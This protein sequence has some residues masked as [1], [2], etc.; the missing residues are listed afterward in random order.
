MTI[1]EIL[2]TEGIGTYELHHYTSLPNLIK[3]L[4]SKKL[5]GGSYEGSD[6]KSVATVR[7]SLG[8]SVKSFLSDDSSGGVKI[9]ID[10]RKMRDKTRGTK[11]KPIAE[12]PIIFK[13]DFE[14]GIKKENIEEVKKIYKKIYSSGIEFEEYIKKYPK[15]KKTLMKY[16]KGYPSALPFN[17]IYWQGFYHP[18]TPREG[19]E[20]IITQSGDLPLNPSYIKI[21]IEP[22]SRIKNDLEKIENKKDV[23]NLFVKN[24]KYFIVDDN[25]KNLLKSLKK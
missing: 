7:P 25:F 8:N 10:N 23:Y 17:Y 20:R 14:N 22:N 21:K 24:R 2:L 5:L 3:I 19:E 12:F 9:I 6:K 11:V 1:N 13:K 16:Y 4:R 18:E 15:V